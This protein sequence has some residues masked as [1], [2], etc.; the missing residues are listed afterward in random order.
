M[1]CR[2]SFRPIVELSDPAPVEYANASRETAVMMKDEQGRPLIVVREL[3][4]LPAGIPNDGP[5]AYSNTTSTTTAKERRR[6]NTETKPSRTTFSPLE[7]SQT[8]SRPP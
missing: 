1:V 2:D 3:V 4:P 8:S 7:P 6:G 5:T